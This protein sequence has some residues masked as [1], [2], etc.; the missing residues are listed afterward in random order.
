MQT[1]TQAFV[2]AAQDIRTVMDATG[3]TFTI[4]RPT[5]LDRLRL[6][7]AIGPALAANDRY[8]GIAML[9]FA[10][11]AMDGVPCP[12]PTNEHQIEAA[13]ERMGDDAIKAIGDSFLPEDK[14]GLAVAGTGN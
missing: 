3:R 9:A 8:M 2:A 12:Q 10:V 1:P 6:F 5:T 14:E 4:R 11:V 13:I 7:K